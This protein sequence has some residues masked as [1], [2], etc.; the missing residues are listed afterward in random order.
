MTTPAEPKK[1][2]GPAPGPNPQKTRALRMD[3]ERWDYFREH[4]GADWLRS[5]I[6]AEIKRSNKPAVLKPTK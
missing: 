2:R 6:D 1:K 3:D 5:K 4:L